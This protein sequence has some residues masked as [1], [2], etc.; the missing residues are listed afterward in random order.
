MMVDAHGKVVYDEY[1][2][3]TSVGQLERLVA[4]HLGVTAG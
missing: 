2:E 1:G 4:R 3:I